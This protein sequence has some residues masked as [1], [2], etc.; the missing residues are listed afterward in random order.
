M[1]RKLQINK[2]DK[3]IRC[4]Q[5]YIDDSRVVKDLGLINI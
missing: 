1:N 3:V 2:G 5:L 4:N